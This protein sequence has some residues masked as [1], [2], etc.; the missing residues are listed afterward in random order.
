MTVKMTDRKQLWNV[1]FKSP[2]AR[3]EIPELE[4][5][6]SAGAQGSL[7]PYV[8]QSSR[9]LQQCVKKAPGQAPSVSRAPLLLFLF[10]L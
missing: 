9:R 1:C 8:G 3:V 7:G 4:F 10:A 5:E 2:H 6:I